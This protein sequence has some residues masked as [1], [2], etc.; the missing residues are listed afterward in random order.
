MEHGK[1]CA[2]AMVKGYNRNRK[3]NVRLATT[4]NTTSQ[5]RHKNMTRNPFKCIIQINNTFF[6]LYK[7]FYLHRGAAKCQG[8]RFGQLET[9][10]KQRGLC[11]H[12]RVPTRQDISY[13]N[14]IR[15]RNNYTSLTH[16]K[17]QIILTSYMPSRTISM[18]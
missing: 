12:Q 18:T 3:Y 16:G 15:T 13:K 4:T 7:C 11:I 9:A 6:E 14:T 8:N 2:Y 5:Q 17:R 10:V 1:R